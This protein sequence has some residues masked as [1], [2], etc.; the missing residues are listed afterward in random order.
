MADTIMQPKDIFART[1][2][3]AAADDDVML[4]LF[5]TRRPQQFGM[6]R[7]DADARVVE[8]VDKPR[9]TALTD[10]WGCMIWRPSFT[11]FLHDG[12][13]HRGMTDFAEIMNAA[14]RAGLRFRG[15]PLVDGTYTDLGTYE[16]IRELD[17]RARE[18]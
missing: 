4:A 17:R 6:V 15:V 9:H 7:L 11:E 13:H 2:Q 10:M 8:I 1:W 16:E 14:I 5:A 12:I 3:Q 18:A